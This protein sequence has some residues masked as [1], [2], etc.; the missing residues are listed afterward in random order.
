MNACWTPEGNDPGYAKLRANGIDT[1]CRSI[2]DTRSSLDALNSDRAAGFASCVYFAANWW[3]D[4][5]R[6]L[7]DRINTYYSAR[8]PN[9]PPDFPM[10]CANLETELEYVSEFLV[11][12]RQ[13]RP[14][15]VTDWALEGHKGGLFT[16][17]FV[18]VVAP[19]VRF[20]VPE[21]YNGA[22]TE[23]WD[24]LAM[25]KDLVAA[26]VPLAQILPFYDAAHLPAWW[27]GYAFHE[28]RLP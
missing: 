13:H 27:Q 14:K 16:P 11:R 17:T 1:I 12:W 5:G 28:G 23:V 20:V 21:L 4:T 3:N 25:A 24:S 10:L 26:G 18:S 8:Y 7:A 19:R 9:T 15:R 22:M 2:R 6:E